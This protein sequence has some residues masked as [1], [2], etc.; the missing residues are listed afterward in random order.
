MAKRQPYLLKNG[1]EVPSVTTLLGNLGWKSFGLMFWAHKIGKQGLDLKDERTK[2]ADVGT[3]V[4]AFAEADITGRPQPE[5]LEATAEDRQKAQDAF[6][7]YLEWKA[8][9]R[10]DPIASE[11]ALVSERYKYGGR[12][13][14]ITSR[15]GDAGLLDFKSSKDLYPDHLVQLAAYHVLWSEN[16]P[17]IPLTSWHLLRWRPDGSFVHHLITRTLLERAWQAFQCCLQLNAIRK[18]LVA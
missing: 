1:T 14:A 15:D 13:D 6:R 3:M 9:T 16:R 2:L 8:S 18:D 5:F 7:G 17:D 12:L 11:I 4:H 10:I